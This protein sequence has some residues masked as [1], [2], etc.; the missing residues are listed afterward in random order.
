MTLRK[1]SDIILLK[2]TKEGDVMK[3]RYCGSEK[4]VVRTKKS[5]PVWAIV[6]AVLGAFPTFFLSLLLLLIK[7]EEDY[8]F[9]NECGSRNEMQ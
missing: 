5:T 8:F 7:K 3:C 9:C 4:V 1:L 6:L 2:N